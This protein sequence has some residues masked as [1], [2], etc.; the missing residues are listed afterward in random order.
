MKLI[1]TADWQIGK[2][3]KQF[4]DKEDSLRRARL[5]AIENIGRVA[6]EENISHVLVAGDVYDSDAPTEVTLRTP[7]E[8]MKLFPGIQWHLLPGNHDPH[9][10]QGIWDR[11]AHAG[12]PPNVHLRLEPRPVPLGHEAIL[13]P[14]PL[15]RKSEV[16][17]ITTWMDAA[18]TGAGLIRIGLAH[19]SIVGFGSRGEANN[20][21]DPARPS[22]ARLD[23]L[24]LGDWHGTTQ[25]GSAAWYAGTPEPDHAGSQEKGTALVVEVPAQGAPAVVRSIHVGTYTWVTLE[26]TLLDGSQLADIEAR[27]RAIDN[28]SCLILRLRLRGA[29]TLSARAELE[30][31]LLSL[32]AAMFHLNVDLNELEA[33]PTTADLE[34]I[35]FDGV[36]RRVADTLLTQMSDASRSIIDRNLAQESLVQLY[37]MVIS[38]AAAEA[39]PC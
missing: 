22:K 12:L 24:A 8:R 2:V 9:R 37:L 7:L 29:V 17:D 10:A 27:V 31:R 19:G 26:E 39:A 1:H 35:D 18:E 21:I 33:R 30:R 28:L 13:L 36:L 16:N 4:G 3:F 15:T 38:Q 25:I 14:A 11:V 6:I 34:A 5:V 20:P 23:Y 32:E